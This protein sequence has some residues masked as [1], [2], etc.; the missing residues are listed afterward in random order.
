MYEWDG[1]IVCVSAFAL[2]AWV[3]WLNSKHP[4]AFK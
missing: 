3:A 2:L 4:E 1:V